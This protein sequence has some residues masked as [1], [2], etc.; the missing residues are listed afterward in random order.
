MLFPARLTAALQLTLASVAVLGQE[1]SKPAAWPNLDQFA[2]TLGT[3]TRTST[4][5]SPWV[6][7]NIS[8]GCRDR[9]LL[10]KRDPTKFKAYTIYMGDCDIPWVICREDGAEPSI[11]KLV[12]T[13]ARVP[14]G[15]RQFVGDVVHFKGGNGA[16]A[17]QSSILHVNGDS[18]GSVAVLIHEASHC[19]DG[20]NG[21]GMMSGDQTWRDAFN[22]D[23]HVAD[24]Y[25]R[26]NHVENFAQ[27]AGL[28]I[29]DRVTNKKLQTFTQYN[30]IV[31]QIRRM[32]TAA[33]SKQNWG[34]KMFDYSGTK[35][36]GRRWSHTPAVNPKTGEIIAKRDFI[37]PR[38][39]GILV[40]S[41]PIELITAPVTNCTIDA[42][43]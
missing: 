13:L 31:Q 40:E 7:G 33:D 20:A 26:T 34:D 19:V 35:K 30:Q 22:K 21:M 10:D 15:M 12:D 23:S 16:S 36:C 6:S 14:V 38:D 9:V 5:I 37:A 29:Y 8:R 3:L 1:I 39:T 11:D 4:R 2:P 18:A 43:I 28:I 41:L 27:Y 24:N 42:S 25:A 17:W 32:A